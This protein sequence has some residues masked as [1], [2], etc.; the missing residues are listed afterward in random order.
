MAVLSAPRP[1]ANTAD[2]TAA[3]SVSTL[4]FEARSIAA[5]HEGA[6]L[7]RQAESLVREALLQLTRLRV[8][9][10]STTAPSILTVIESVELPPR[11]PWFNEADSLFPHATPMTPDERAA[12]ASFRRGKS[13][14]V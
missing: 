14:P 1:T 6:E 4:V 7:E 11:P 3:T 9:T 2:Q 5:G 10:R 12:L 13:R 8:M